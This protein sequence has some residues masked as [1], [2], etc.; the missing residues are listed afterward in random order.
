[1]AAT[2]TEDVV[3]VVNISRKYKVPIIPFGVGNSLEGHF[4][5]VRPSV[6]HSALDQPRFWQQHPAGSICIDLSGMDKIIAIHGEGFSSTPSV[7]LTVSP[8]EDGDLIC[9]AGARWDEINRILEERG[10]PLFFPVCG[11][12]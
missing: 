8:E 10:I 4:A 5:G 6:I 7:R 12:N 11:R 9:Q 3:K 1:V 2:S